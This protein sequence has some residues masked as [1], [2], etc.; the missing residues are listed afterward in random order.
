M[1]TSQFKHCQKVLN[2]LVPTNCQ[3]RFAGDTIAISTI[4][5]STS[6]LHVPNYSEYAYTCTVSV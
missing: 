5:I 3:A 1:C 2:W 4:A 6:L